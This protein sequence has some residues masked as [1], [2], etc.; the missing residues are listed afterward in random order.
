MKKYDIYYDKEGISG[1]PNSYWILTDGN[2]GEPM[3][4]RL[5]PFNQ[6]CAMSAL[7]DME[8]RGNY[9]DDKKL[10]DLWKNNPPIMQS[11]F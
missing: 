3:L 7:H 2:A 5:G 10:A 11:D 4:G 1:S 6:R 9:G 8:Y